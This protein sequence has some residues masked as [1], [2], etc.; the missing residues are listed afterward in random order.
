V[1][2]VVVQQQSVE[3]E[4][5][6]VRAVPGLV[7]VLGRWAW[8]TTLRP[9]SA[10]VIRP[11]VMEVAG[12]LLEYLLVL[13]LVLLLLP[14]LPL[15]LLLLLLVSAAVAAAGA[16]AASSGPPEAPE[17]ETGRAPLAAH[18]TAPPQLSLA[19]CPSLSALT[20]H[21]QTGT[22]SRSCTAPASRTGTW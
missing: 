15:P 16:A 2:W 3:E 12:G 9:G 17:P 4:A 22:W 6:A 1:A 10:D 5:A 20:Q 18:M 21:E 8:H 7:V 11:A 19:Q 13:Q 14:H